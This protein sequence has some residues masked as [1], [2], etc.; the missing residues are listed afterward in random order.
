[1][2]KKRSSTR[3]MGAFFIANCSSGCVLLKEDFL[4]RLCGEWAGDYAL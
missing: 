3:L 1:M 2:Q 4:R